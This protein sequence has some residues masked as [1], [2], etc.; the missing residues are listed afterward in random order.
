MLALCAW[1]GLVKPANHAEPGARKIP[2]FA[3]L[4]GHYVGDL[5]VNK[6]SLMD[7]NIQAS[8][9]MVHE[10]RPSI[11]VVLWVGN[12]RLTPL[13]YRQGENDLLGCTD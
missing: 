2:C 6:K 13:R 5:V 7:L 11:D 8:K 9:L 3:K 4:G 10:W 12:Q 1:L